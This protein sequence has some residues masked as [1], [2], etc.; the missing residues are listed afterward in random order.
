MPHSSTC[1][2]TNTTTMAP[3]QHS[4][5]SLLVHPTAKSI[6]CC[7]SRLLLYSYF[8]WEWNYQYKNPVFADCKVYYN[9]NILCRV[10][11]KYKVRVPLICLLGII[12][13]VH[14][15]LKCFLLPS[16][17]K[18]KICSTLHLF[19]STPQSS[20]THMCTHDTSTHTH[21]YCEG[22]VFAHNYAHTPTHIHQEHIEPAKPARKHVTNFSNIQIWKGSK[23]ICTCIAVFIESPDTVQE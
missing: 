22:R 2:L 18:I 17:S 5:H 1:S 12:L 16:A 19:F 10:R 14:K 8:I 15:Q 6:L 11:T 4:I 23:L 13:Q 20:Q 3:G 9:W 21:M 7:C